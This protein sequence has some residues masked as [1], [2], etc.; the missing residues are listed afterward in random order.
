MIAIARISYWL[1]LTIWA[2]MLAS[3]GVAATSVFTVLPRAGVTIEKFASYDH[4]A[5]GRI[6]AGMVMDPIFAF[7]DLGQLAGMIMAIAGFA[8]MAAKSRLPLR[9]PSGI[10][11]AA[12]LL[13]ASL[14][15]VGR[16]VTLTPAMNR[17]LRSYWKAAEAGDTPAAAARQAKFDGMHPMA[18]K[19]FNATL[20]ALLAT[21]AA[22]AVAM[23]RPASAAGSGLE[24]PSLARRRP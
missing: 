3:A 13:I 2:S 7:V 22:S 11:M 17:E 9:R 16:A 8:V 10:I 24:S 15:F 1:G 5:H 12:G 20:V 6:A 4:A 18:S 21:V 14:L 19:L 23:D